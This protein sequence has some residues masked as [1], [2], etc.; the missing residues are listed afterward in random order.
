MLLAISGDVHPPL[1]YLLL[2]PLGQIRNAPAWIIRIPSLIFSI[3]A[4]FVFWSILDKLITNT[5]VRRSAW[6][7]FALS[8]T[9]LY[10]TG[11]GRMY[12]WLGLLVLC[13]VW[14]ILERRWWSLVIISIMILWS[15]N[16]GLIYVA[17]LWAAGMVLKWRNW[18]PLT[19]ALGLAGVT[20]IPWIGILHS[21]METIRGDYWI[22]HLTWPSALYAFYQSFS[23]YGKLVNDIVG[24]FIFFGW[25]VF[26]LFWILKHLRSLHREVYAILIL[27]FGPFILAVIGSIVWQPILLYRA[28]VPAAPF[29]GLVL[30]IPLMGIDNKSR[31][32]SLAF[33]LIVPFLVINTS[34]IYIPGYHLRGVDDAQMI[35]TLRIIEARWKPGDKIIHLG[36][37]SLVDMLPYAI[38]PEDHFKY[39]P[40]GPVRGS[41]SPRTREGLGL[42]LID[43]DQITGHV[44][45]LT[46]E[47]PMTPACNEIV[48]SNLV[49]DRQPVYCIVDNLLQKSCLYEFTYSH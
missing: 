42:Q 6:V 24:E 23:L 26:S 8:S 22:F 15:H 31:S 49:H 33:I 41:L 13:A 18:K 21:Q 29:I 14:T 47:S 46:E 37:G 45:L 27:A 2:W 30:S 40:C 7:L 35:R 28:L 25:L 5:I 16:Y 39:Q 9:W 11:E 19:L 34:R 20:F 3:A 44:W 43:P 10:Y 36:D 38:H 32:V 1:Y 17:C 48:I 4:L 12:A